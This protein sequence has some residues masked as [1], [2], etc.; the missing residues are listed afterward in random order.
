MNSKEFVLNKLDS[1]VHK[2]PG[3]E[4]LY[5]FDN[6]INTHVVE[7]HPF[8]IFESLHEYRDLETEISFEF[9]ET[10]TSENLLFISSNSLCKV[11]TP[12]LVLTGI[13]HNI[14]PEIIEPEIYKFTFSNS[15]SYSTDKEIDFAKAA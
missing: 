5:Q 12:D 9:D 15:V 13:L 2:F 7:I 3:I 11:V 1:L 4:I 14:I 10:Y 8:S 6:Q